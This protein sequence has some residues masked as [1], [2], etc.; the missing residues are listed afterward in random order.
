MT[1]VTS[2]TVRYIHLKPFKVQTDNMSIKAS[3]QIAYYR[4]FFG[5]DCELIWLT[6]SVTLADG[7]HQCPLRAKA[8]T[9]NS[10]N[11]LPANS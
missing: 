2:N 10:P 9:Q 11:N 4:F 3:I 8:M 7:H 1:L 6:E 5:P